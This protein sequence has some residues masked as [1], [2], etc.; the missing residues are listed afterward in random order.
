MLWCS[1]V[2]LLAHRLLT[3]N[4]FG[5]CFKIIFSTWDFTAL[6]PSSPNG[7]IDPERGILL[8]SKSFKDIQD[9]EWGNIFKN[10]NRGEG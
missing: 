2:R 8:F 7:L 10:K 6:Y 4:Y 3:I 1:K 5:S 9:L